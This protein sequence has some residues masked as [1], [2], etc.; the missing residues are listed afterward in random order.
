M[1]PDLDSI[2]VSVCGIDKRYDE[3][4]KLMLLLNENISSNSSTKITQWFNSL[5]WKD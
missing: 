4:E 2:V 1:P 5:K 3:S